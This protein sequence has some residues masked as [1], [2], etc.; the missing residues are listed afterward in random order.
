MR[1][2][3]PHWGEQALV[4]VAA[5]SV[6]AGAAAAVFCAMNGSLRLFPFTL[7]VIFGTAAG[8]GL[9]IYLAVRRANRVSWKTAVIAGFCIGAIVPAFIALTGPG[10]SQSSVGGVPTVVNGAYTAAGWL[11]VLTLVGASGLLGTVGG[12]V[13][14]GG[15]VLVPG[16][17]GSGERESG[18]RQRFVWRH[19]VLGVTA[20]G[21]I[22]AALTI[23]EITADRSC[24]NSLRD[25]RKSIGAAASFRV[26]VQSGE[27]KHVEAAAS[28]FG[29]EHGWSQ[30][31][32][33]RPADSLP[34]FSMSLCTEPG[35]RISIDALAQWRHVSV[36][37]YQPQG[38]TSWREPMAALVQA[39]RVSW[40]DAIEF[41]GPMGEK[42]SPP[43]WV[44]QP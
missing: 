22:A 5:L 38:D 15:I 12:L 44:A 23:P 13:F 41:T 34:W 1:I 8:L 27:W 39:M 11:E 20:I 7:L 14:W 24:H 30:R 25:G 6:G 28:R 18:T 42:I 26:R 32:D 33:V 36:A 43:E 17:G 31:S 40:P 35:T 9:P 2:A 4:H 37:A 10:A 19:M 3:V 16:F 21:T 29:Q